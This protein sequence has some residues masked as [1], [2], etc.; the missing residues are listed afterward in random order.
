[1]NYDNKL[2]VTL[3]DNF[4]Y[5]QYFLLHICIFKAVNIYRH[6]LVSIENDC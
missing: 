1:M 5:V 2:I 6:I 3:Y 4:F